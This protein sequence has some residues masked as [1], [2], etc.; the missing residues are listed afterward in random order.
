MD[1]SKTIGLVFIEGLADWEFGLLAASA[2]EWFGARTLALTPDG[3][4]VRSIAG[5]T[6]SGQRGLSPEENADLDAVAL[7]GSDNWPVEVAPNPDKEISLPVHQLALVVNGVHLLEN[8]KLDEL[9]AK[10][11][12]TVSLCV[13]SGDDFDV[14]AEAAGPRMV[15]VTVGKRVG[16]HFPLHASSTGKVILAELPPERIAAVLPEELERFTAKTITSRAALLSELA[17]VREQG[18]AIIDNELEEELLS[19]ARPIR[20]GAGGL[21]AVLSVDGPR[22]RFGRSRIPEALQLMRD[23]VERIQDLLWQERGPDQSG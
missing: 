15:N 23:S 14:I 3:Q 6:L 8:M 1:A 13:P 17:D 2:V 7:I 9:A 11:N 16:H 20:D 21:A 4:P 5:F 18:Y 12:E 10:L 19:V 22:H